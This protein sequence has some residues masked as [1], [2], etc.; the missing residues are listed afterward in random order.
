VQNPNHHSG[1]NLA[2]IAIIGTFLASC[3]GEG[4]LEQFAPSEI[5][6]REHGELKELIDE[7]LVF[8]DA[9]GMEWI[10]PQGTLTD[11]ASVPRWAL[12]ITNGRWDSAFLKAAVVHDA[13]CQSDN[14]T[15]AP[16]QYRSRP[17]QAVHRMFHEAI[18]AGGTTPTLAK[19]MFAAVWLK[20]PRWDDTGADADA[21]PSEAL[22][23]GFSGAIGWIETSD[24]SIEAIEQDLERRRPLLVNLYD[25][26]VSIER[27]LEDDEPDRADALIQR[28]RALLERELES[29]PDD[30]MLQ[31]FDGHLYKNRAFLDQ[32]VGRASDLQTNLSRA[33]ASFE[34]VVEMQPEQPSALSGLSA[35]AALRGDQVRAETLANDALR[36]APENRGVLRDLERIERLRRED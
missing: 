29:S 20:G 3:N 31:I 13:Y 23:R 12:P 33:E 14:E 6:F 34:A 1:F 19:V 2:L 35:T 24:P 30:A 8:T 11:G 18:L 25:L 15:R 4:H 28:E 7:R 9:Q 10:A 32:K 22:N 36:I 17:W 5:S 26:E 27:A 16:D 21:V